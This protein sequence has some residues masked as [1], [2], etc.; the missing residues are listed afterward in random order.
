MDNKLA[1]PE[2]LRKTVLARLHRAHPGQEAM[3]SASEYISW[4]LLSRQ[5]VD[6]CE[7]FRKSTLYGKNLK[8][9]KTFKT[10]KQL[11]YLSGPNQELQLDFA[12][13][14]LDVKGNKTFLLVA[15]GRFSNIPSFLITKTTGAKTVVKFFDSYICI[16]GLPQS[17]RTDH[18]SGF[19]NDMVKHFFF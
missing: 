6:T 7:K 5:I 1:I 10:A 18:R 17:I 4:P 14:I 9:T 19:K 13:P 3:M 2:P 16:H 11:P 8:P 15:F 12:G